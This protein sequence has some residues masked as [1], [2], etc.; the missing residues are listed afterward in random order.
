M[1]VSCRFWRFLPCSKTHSEPVDR[2]HRERSQSGL[3]DRLD[4]EPC[5]LSS[6]NSPTTKRVGRE[7]A[8][9][10]RSATPIPAGLRP[11][12][13]NSPVTDVRSP[14]TIQPTM[15]TAFAALLP[16]DRHIVLSGWR[17]VPWALIFAVVSENGV[18]HSS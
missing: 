11:G 12:R 15:S 1:Q 8:A 6:P 16:I 13:I 9:P 17:L 2:E 10:R 5:R 7:P 18:A 4:A 3:Q 14:T